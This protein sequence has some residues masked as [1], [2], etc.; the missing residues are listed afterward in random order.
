MT[1]A[2]VDTAAADDKSEKKK[3]ILPLVLGLVLTILG[4]GA[5]FFM[6]SSGL[7]GGT[8][9]NLDHAQSGE[10]MPAM[11]DSDTPTEVRFVY[12]PPLVVSLGPEVR[13]RHLQ[14]TAAIETVAGAEDA[15]AALEPRILDVMNGYLRALAP[16]DIE[17]PDGL[18]V[19]RA[20]LTRRLQLVLGEERMRDLL[21]MEF[22]LN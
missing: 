1:D 13:M 4:A 9:D 12:L 16:S 18:F 10:A 6:V 15:V 22:V 14:F 21:V 19:V 7:V 8:P 5:G 11:Y 2:T 3:R 20:Q 17:A